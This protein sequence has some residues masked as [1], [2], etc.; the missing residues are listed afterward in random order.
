MALIC[1]AVEIVGLV[2]TGIATAPWMAKMGVFLAGAGFSLVFPH[3]AWS[4]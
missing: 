2:L 1:F 4:R 3:S